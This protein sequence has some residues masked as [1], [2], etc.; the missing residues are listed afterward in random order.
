V[1][2]ASSRSILVVGEHVGD[3]WDLAWALHE[4]GIV[5]EQVS[6][7]DQACDRLAHGGLAGIVVESA[8]G[9]DVADALL[10]AIKPDPITGELPFVLVATRATTPAAVV[11]RV[12][13]LVATSDELKL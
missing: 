12:Q 10:S 3:R 1:A 6:S 2:D 13:T 5:A 8:L 11:A 7:A 9:D 4:A